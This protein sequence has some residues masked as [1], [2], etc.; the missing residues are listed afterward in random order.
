[1]TSPAH[2]EARSAHPGTLR[3]A[4]PAR[5][6][7]AGRIAESPGPRPPTVR[8]PIE[9]A[10]RQ[11]VQAMTQ[12]LCCDEGIASIAAANFYSKFH[13]T[14]EFSR[15]TGTTPRRYLAAL[16][17]QRAKD[18]LLKSDLGVVDVSTTVG[19]MSVG[20]FSSRFS[21]LVGVSPREWRRCRGR[22]SASPDVHG[23]GRTVLRGHVHLVEDVS[24]RPADLFVAVYEDSVVQGRP[25][26]CARPELGTSFE[27]TGV[28][29]GSWMVSVLLRSLTEAGTEI[30]RD[31]CQVTV[32]DDPTTSHLPLRLQPTTPCEFDPPVIFSGAGFLPAGGDRGGC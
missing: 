20:T 26:A 31:R 3:L 22:T 12:D 4:A 1:M 30:L 17:M 23:P 15:I 5:R 7:R 19:Y 21:A 24:R 2:S 25:V 28:P 11:A 10:V 8:T 27:L 16:R 6:A 14:R 18:L 29:A 13:F 9:D 32:S